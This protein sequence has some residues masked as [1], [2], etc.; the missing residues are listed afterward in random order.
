MKKKLVISLVAAGCLFAGPV[1]ANLDSADLF[2]RWYDK[3]FSATESSVQ[4]QL[5]SHTVGTW[6]HWADWNMNLDQMIID[7]LDMTDLIRLKSDEM[8]DYADKQMH[9]IESVKESLH[10]TE[11]DTLTANHKENLPGDMEEELAEYFKTEIL[12]GE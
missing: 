2:S 4:Q 1:A 6:F 9:R 5:I 12:N 3:Q 10:T 8:N 11:L 7:Q